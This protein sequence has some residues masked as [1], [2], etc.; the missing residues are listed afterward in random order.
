MDSSA[1]KK[2]KIRKR[3]IFHDNEN[4]QTNPELRANFTKKKKG[5]K[6][7]LEKFLNE[8]ATRKKIPQRLIKR[9]DEKHAF[10]AV[11]KVLN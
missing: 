11:G 10:L 3:I 1:S 4:K 6:F 5:V 8:N 9:N 7:V 2:R